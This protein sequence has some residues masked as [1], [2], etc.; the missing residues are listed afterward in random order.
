M[1]DLR[2]K[3]ILGLLEISLILFFFCASAFLRVGRLHVR[4]A[5]QPRLSLLAGSECRRL[6]VVKLLLVALPESSAGQRNSVSPRRGEEIV[7]NVNNPS[8]RGCKKGETKLHQRKGTSS[9]RA[10]DVGP[11]CLTVTMTSTWARDLEEMSQA[12]A[13]KS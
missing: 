8:G 2:R 9:V 4:S 1:S 10:T 7:G 13:A 5:E 6:S 11:D 3:S 12:A